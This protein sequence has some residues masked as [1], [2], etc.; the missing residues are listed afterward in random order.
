MNMKSVYLFLL[1]ML[2]FV[3]QADAASSRS[4]AIIT[5]IIPPRAELKLNDTQSLATKQNGTN[6]VIK[7]GEARASGNS[8]YSIIVSTNDGIATYTVVSP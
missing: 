1:L 2:A 7:N 3:S 8:P 6:L 4:H 5:V